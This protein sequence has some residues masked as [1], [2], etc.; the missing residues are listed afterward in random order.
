MTTHYNCRVFVY[1]VIEGIRDKITKTTMGVYFMVLNVIY[2]WIERVS[3]VREEVVSKIMWGVC[4]IKDQVTFK[5]RSS[6]LR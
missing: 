2:S 3:L 4:K 5:K 6:N 1:S